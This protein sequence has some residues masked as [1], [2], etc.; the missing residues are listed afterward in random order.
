MI[1]RVLEAFIQDG[2][3]GFANTDSLLGSFVGGFGAVGEKIVAV[4]VFAQR[5][6]PQTRASIN[7]IHAVPS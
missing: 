4:P 6:V 2:A 5:L 7:Q 1:Q 3:G